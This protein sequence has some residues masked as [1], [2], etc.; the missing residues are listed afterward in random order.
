MAM[1]SIRELENVERVWGT[2]IEDPHRFV[3]FA[4][5][6]KFVLENLNITPKDSVEEIQDKYK[7][8]IQS[9]TNIYNEIQ[10]ETKFDDFELKV[11]LNRLLEIVY[12]SQQMIIGYKRI[13]EAMDISKDYR[14]NSDISLFRYSAVDED[15]TTPFQKLLLYLLEYTHYHKYSRY[16]G[17]CY[18]QV[19]IKD[20]ESNSRNTYAWKYVCDIPELIYNSVQKNVSFEQFKN[21]THAGN[22]VR[23]AIEFMQNCVDAQFPTLVKDR[24][25]FSFKNGVYFAKYIDDNG[26]ITDRFMTYEQIDRGGIKNICSSKYFDHEFTNG[27]VEHANWRDIDTPVLDSILEYQDLSRDIIETVYM[28]IGRLIYDV[29][30][31]DGWQVIFF[32]QGQAGTGKSTLTLNVCK[33]LYDDEDVGVLSNNV[34]KKFGLADIADSI[35]FV[36]PEIKRDFSMEQ[37]EFQS[38]ISGDKV[39]IN[40]KH[41]KSQFVNWNIPGIMAGNETPDFVDNSGSIQRRIV[42]VKFDKRVK[43][44]DMSLGRR[45]NEEMHAIVKKCNCAYQE[46]A[47][48]YGQ[49]NVWN[50][51]PQYFKTTQNE[52]AQATNSLMHFLS[53]GK[54]RIKEGAYIPEKVFISEFNHHCNE[55]NYTK[56]RFNKDF[57]SGPFSS[58]GVKVTKSDKRRYP[59]ETGKYYT[60]MFFE[61]I[62]L[63]DDDQ[64]NE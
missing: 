34:Q 12:Y 5:L 21:L 42:T 24:H 51:L 44:G 11:R 54:V 59:A 3:N 13:T 39:T 33:N 16:N 61:N 2:S 6:S 26:E 36:A 15:D 8:Q 18:K 56:H 29:N 47:K 25:V 32:F 38:I 49:K 30:E 23:N 19:Y 28:F 20:N 1:T 45:L 17:S 22:N 57:Y 53:S 10:K 63:A 41:Q 50:I 58:V 40:V 46:A 35:L 62:E 4:T 31:M 14:D 55:N 48:E 7:V 43:D 64:A 27:S 60:G 9:L 37:G 52:L